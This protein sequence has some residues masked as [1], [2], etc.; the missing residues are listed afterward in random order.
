LS[1]LLRDDAARAAL[2][3]VRDLDEVKQIRDKA[4]A[5]QYYAR[6]A[7]DSQLIDDA[8]EIRIRA[9]R[10]AGELLRAMAEN[11]ERD[12]GAGGDRKSQSHVA[13]VKLADLEISKTQSSRWQKLAALDEGA[14]E[15]RTAAAK[16]Q[17][18]ASVEMTRAERTAE[19]KLRR[20]QREA[21]L[22]ARQ[23]A[24]PDKRYGVIYADPEWRFDVWSDGGM[25]RAA[26]N[27]YPTSPIDAI[28]ARRVEKI[29]AD[30]CVL[31]L[32]ATAPMLPEG[33]RVVAA[34]GFRYVSHFVWNKDRIG[35]GYWNRNKHELLLI[36]T[37]G[38]IPAPAMGTQ[39]DSVIDA[40]L[41]GHSAKPENF[42]DLIE[43]YFPSLPKIELNRRGPPR[44]GWDAWGNEALTVS[45][46]HEN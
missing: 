16:K 23:A 1:E 12:A 27:H 11:G 41:G 26:D 35:T 10:R 36:G 6:Q 2:A 30:D 37:R 19:K 39:W 20:Q 31:F 3:E 29:A 24:L 21:E 33:L 8:T 4:L 25:D 14:F 34:W 46:Q 44:P 18:L 42:L 15:A 5:M 40:P 7:K 22:G 38:D 13:T 43:A 17:A 28:C 45:T 32:W 9:E